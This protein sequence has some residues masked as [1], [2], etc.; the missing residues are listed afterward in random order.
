M[1]PRFRPAFLTFGLLCSVLSAQQPSSAPSPSQASPAQATV[2]ST[3]NRL[4]G[5]KVAEI[6]IRSHGLAQTEWL[7]PLL[8]QKVNEP[9]D[10]NKVRL[11]VQAL[12]DTGRFSQ[13]Q[14]EAQ[15]NAKGDLVL[16]FDAQ[17]N[18]FFGSI[19]VEGA[20]APPTDNQLVNAGRLVLGEQFTEDAIKSAIAGM[21]RVMQDNGYYQATVKPSYEWVQA[22][23][24]VKVVF[25]IVQGARARVGKITVT[26]SPGETYAEII[27]TAKLEPGDHVSAS[28]VTRA[29][30]RLRQKYQKQDRLTAQVVLAQRVY[31]PENNTLDYTFDISRGPVV[32]VKVE[33]DS[34]HHNLIKKYVPIYE[35]N[36]VDDDLL[37]EGRGNIKDYLQTQGYYDA[38]VEYTRKQDPAADRD[39]ITF[40]IDRGERHKV[41]EI[42][43][44]GNKYFTRDVITER[45][46][47]QPSGGPLLVGR[48]S[49]A[50]VARDVQ[51]IERLYHSNGFLRVKVTPK[52]EDDIE[53]KSAHI[54]VTM[55]I[56]EGPQTTVG[57]LTIKGN[58]AV[59]ADVLR[60]LVA[61][62]E[63]QPYADDTVSKDQTIIVA[64]Y[65]NRGF[66]G[67]KMEYSGKPSASDP[68]KV[69]LI[70]KI[71]EGPRVYVDQVLIS[72][73]HYT[74][75]FVVEREMKIHS[76]D[77]LDQ[78]EMLETQR[79]L[80]DLGIF[81]A[82]DMAIQNPEGDA[83]HKNVVY[84]V[85][86][87]KRYTFNY[88][89]G[90]EVQSGQPAGATQPQGE[91]GA[92]A[93]V[94]LDVTRLNF[95]GRDHTIT[96]KTR[97]GNLQ[98]RAL[99]SYD[100]PRFFNQEKLTFNFTAFYDDT[101][102]VRTFEAK[103]LEGSAEIR[104]A[105]NAS[106]TLLYRYTYRRVSIP[107]SSL[108]IDPNLVP[109]F[110]QPV[111]VGLPSFTLVR[112]TRDDPTSSHKG[113]FTSV[114]MGVAAGIFGSQT[115]FARVV[116][117]NTT[118][119]HFRKKRWILARS[120][121]VGVETKFGGTT[122]IPLPERFLSG[123]SNSQRG[124]GLNQAGPRDLT[125]GFPLGGEALFLNNVELRTPPLPLRWAGNNLSAVV[126]HDM[127][128]VFSSPTEAVHSLLRWVQPN[129]DTC[130]VPAAKNCNFNYMS[131][132]VGSGIRYL[133][134]IG[135]IGM[136]V[137][138][139]L[140]PTVFPIASQNRSETLK[141]FNFFFTIGQTF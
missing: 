120:T 140:N 45:M 7:Q 76:G 116:G 47:S 3:L 12:Y 129:R 128:N 27:S 125:T 36:A 58:T 138:Y 137:G 67:V 124:F 122:F 39:E 101:F 9:L 86:E 60:G 102:D 105:W 75:P 70:Y 133:T 40:N 119:Y 55:D 18:Y 87:A 53:G 8:A 64:E 84:Q 59:S 141:R 136:D 20:P 115:N 33:G 93:R 28:N 91:P 130:L 111:R 71:T 6:E 50:T 57:K 114:D 21:Q 19:R 97:Y 69:E 16:I 104:Q 32:E 49:Q 83:T 43:I 110:S 113:A 127:G 99:I 65:F 46:E 94:S 10:K 62:T 13:I 34:L 139:N 61:A 132:A 72:G 54:K 4:Q 81:N 66:P 37:N 88:G 121:R 95:R 89:V 25:T 15:Q 22:E 92:S 68:T 26:G 77:P 82:V 79:R 2:S 63:G 42:V 135:P 35:E 56:N 23:Q 123:G 108:V 73:L 85:E 41:E 44:V 126:F 17:E 134:P 38:K 29:L 78:N 5:T 52:V 98:K 80:Y 112:D 51:A 96:L 30:K 31:H 100:A 90:F 74:K 109:L 106:T 117:Q 24:Q 14:V 1:L 48:F 11:S 103:R 118:Y 131:H 107:G